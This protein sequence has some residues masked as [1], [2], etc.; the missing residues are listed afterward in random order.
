[1]SWV[2]WRQHRLEG[3]WSLIAVALMAVGIVIVTYEM[4]HPGC[5][6][7]LPGPGYCLPTDAA[8]TLAE[9]ILRVNLV[10]YGLVVLPALAGAFIGAPLGRVISRMA[11]T[12]SPGHRE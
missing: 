11:R 5:P 12:G 4:G 9:W 6:R 3:L 8:G 2:T 7:S 1:V 10:N